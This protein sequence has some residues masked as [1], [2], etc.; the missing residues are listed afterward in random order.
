[1]TIGASALSYHDDKRIISEPE[2]A[3]FC[4]LSLVHFRRLRRNREGPNFVQLTERRIGYRF[5]DIDK[6]LEERLRQ[7]NGQ[8]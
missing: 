7:T 3:A 8:G 1:M 6:W 2:A 4:C 5:R